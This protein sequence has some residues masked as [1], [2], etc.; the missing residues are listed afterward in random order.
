[1]RHDRRRKSRQR[2]RARFNQLLPEL[3]WLLMVSIWDRY[4]SEVNRQLMV[5]DGTSRR[6]G[7][8][9]MYDPPVKLVSNT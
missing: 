9:D 2:K 1:M 4:W 7:F 8:S 5:G 3:E 6:G